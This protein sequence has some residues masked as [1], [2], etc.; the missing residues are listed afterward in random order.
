MAARSASTV[1]RGIRPATS[2]AATSCRTPVGVPSSPRRIT[3]PSG[4]GVDSPTPPAASA[5]WLA[6]SEWWSCAQSATR[7]PGAARSRSSAVGQRPRRSGS[8]PAPSIHASPAGCAA[9]ASRTRATSTSIE[10]ASSS[11]TRA[12]ASAASTRCRWESVRPGTAASSGPSSMTRVPGPVAAST[13]PT[14]PAAT[15]RPFA[16]PMA[17]TQPGP[18]SPARVAIRPRTTRVACGTAGSGG[19]EGLMTGS[20][21]PLSAGAGARGDDR[22]RVGRHRQRAS[23]AASGVATHPAASAG[24]AAATPGFCCRSGDAPPRG[25][26]AARRRPGPGRRPSSGP[27]TSPSSP[28]AAAGRGG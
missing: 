17:S 18:S 16:M 8:H 10:S 9:A 14:L 4:S 6:S 12:R 13:S 25:R 1:G 21:S 20:S 2:R 28:P 23:A 11:W 26:P 5:A 15:T 19:Q 24:G 22:R 27:S 3:P 7:R